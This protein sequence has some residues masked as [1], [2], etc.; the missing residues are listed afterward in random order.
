MDLLLIRHAQTH[1][2]VARALD[3]AL[4]G[5]DLTELGERQVAD[6]A[7]QLADEHLDAVWC[8][9]TLRTRRTAAAI[10]EPRGLDLRVHHGLVEISAGHWEMSTAE[11]HGQAYREAVVEGMLGRAGELVPGGETRDQVLGRFDAVVDEIRGSGHGRVAVVAH[12]AVL[13]AWCGVRVPNVPVELVRDRPLGN[14]GLVRLHARG[15]GW[16][17]SEWDTEVVEPGGEAGPVA[18]PA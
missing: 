17:A 4:P 13:R 18:E 12:G 2:N 8:S 11:E 10:A 9:P 1:S 15:N 14:T 3:T 7:D 6:L 5:A 16:V